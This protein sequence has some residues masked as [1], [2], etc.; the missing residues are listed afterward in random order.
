MVNKSNIFS[1]FLNKPDRVFRHK[2]PDPKETERIKEKAK[3]QEDAIKGT[4]PSGGIP[5]QDEST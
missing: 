2:A 4:E 3:A 1:D 5:R